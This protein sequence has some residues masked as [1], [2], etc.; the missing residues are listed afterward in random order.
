MRKQN[1]YLET[2]PQPEAL[3]D[4]RFRTLLGAEAWRTLPSPIRQ[5]FSKRL[6]PGG[7][8]VYTGEIVEAELSR[9]GRVLAHLCRLIGGP[10]PL[11]TDTGVASVV[12]VTEDARN[13]GQ[14]WTRLYASRSGFPQTIHST[15]RFEGETGL[16]EHIGCGIGMSLSVS[17]EESALVFRQ[18]R[19]FVACGGF[20]LGLPSWLTPGRLTVKHIELGGG[21]FA[22]TLDV[23]HPSLGQLIHQ[24]VVFRDGL[25]APAVPPTTC[26]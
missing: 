17:A 11:A 2:S 13:G 23:V 19:Y 1:R 22:F 26:R 10:L 18:H 9:A 25:Q 24:R 5:R 4:T 3:G 14:V 12:T 8:V 7:S 6:P 16:E 21:R 15:K 20:R